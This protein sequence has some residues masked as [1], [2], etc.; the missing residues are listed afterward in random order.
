MTV[1]GV[2]INKGMYDSKADG[3]A[4]ASDNLPLLLRRFNSGEFDRVAV[5]RSLLRDP[6][7]ERKARLG[8]PFSAFHN[9]ALESLV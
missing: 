3:G 9:S 7:W 8:Q 1:G 4:Q 5:G 2:G 6:E